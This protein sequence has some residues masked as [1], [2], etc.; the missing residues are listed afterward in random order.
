MIDT[1]LSG[2]TWVEVT[3]TLVNIDTFESLEVHGRDTSRLLGRAFHLTGGSWSAFLFWIWL[4][5]A[6]ESC[7]EVSVDT[8]L[9]RSTSVSSFKTLV[10]ILAREASVDIWIRNTF[11]S[12]LAS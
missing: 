8:E 10:D 2:G 11:L 3:S 5:S 1:V 4:T 7:S 6:D 12:R 9:L